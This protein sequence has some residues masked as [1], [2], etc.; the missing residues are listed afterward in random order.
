MQPQT[1]PS[2][3]MQ[4]SAHHT[5]DNAMLTEIAAIETELN[6][7]KADLQTAK[8]RIAAKAKEVLDKYPLL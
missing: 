6:Q 7:V 8:E 5:E 1:V 2:P 4:R 3:Q